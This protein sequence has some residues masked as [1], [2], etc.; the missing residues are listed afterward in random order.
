MVDLLQQ[1]SDWLTR[2]RAATMATVVTYSRPGVSPAEPQTVS[3]AATVDSTAFEIDNGYG[4]V[5][6]VVSRDF[7]LTRS[8]LVLGGV[9]VQ[10]KPGDQITET[11]V[12]GTFVYESMSPGKEPCWRWSDPHRNTVR[13][14]TKQVQ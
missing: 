3:L 10:P 4:V 7:L 13:V 6:Q 1:A 2:T 12:A 9:V 5:E 8:D 11:T 14:H